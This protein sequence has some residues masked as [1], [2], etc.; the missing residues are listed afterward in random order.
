M[1][2]LWQKSVS[3]DVFYWAIAQTLLRDAAKQQDCAGQDSPTSISSPA[4]QS[5]I[6]ASQTAV[7]LQ[8]RNKKSAFVSFLRAR[9]C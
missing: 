7:L 1:E 8:V 3:T 4:V 9:A 2:F 6:L 5:R